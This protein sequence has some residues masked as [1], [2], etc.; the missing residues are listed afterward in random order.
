MNV[1]LGFAYAQQCRDNAGT[2][3]GQCRDNAG[4]MQGQCRDNEVKS[5]IK[6][7]PAQQHHAR[8]CVIIHEYFPF[9]DTMLIYYC[10]YYTYIVHI[11][12]LNYDLILTRETYLIN[13][14]NAK[15]Q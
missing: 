1:A 14:M 15:Y 3:Q 2:M 10:L 8:K 6:H 11:N 7:V 9:C 13:C 5:M 12:V 4:T